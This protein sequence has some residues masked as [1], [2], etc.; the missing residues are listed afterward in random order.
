MA[1]LDNKKYR[2]ELKFELNAKYA[3]ILKYKFSLIMESEKK[4]YTVNGK[5]YVR[6]LYFDDVYNTAYYEKIDGLE[7][8]K[9][10]RIR[11]YNLDKS[12][13]ILE[14]KGKDGNLTY[15]KSDRITVNEYYDLINQNYDKIN[16]D[17]R[18][19][20]SEFINK[21]KSNNLIF[22]MLT[23][24]LYFTPFVFQYPVALQLCCSLMINSF[25]SI[26]P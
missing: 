11:L 26:D 17:D 20:L 14:L 23:F 16:I 25:N 6:S 15:K 2:H 7:K 10:Y 24:K 8:R 3:E 12:Y 19:V 1:T 9:K 4:E 5:Y 22:D 21:S 13:I 18:R